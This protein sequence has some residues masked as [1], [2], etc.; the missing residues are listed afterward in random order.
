MIGEPPFEGPS[1]QENLSVVAVLEEKI[2][3]RLTGGSGFVIKIPE[4]PDS[5]NGDA[6]YAFIACT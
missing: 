3:A 5:E 6:P 1:C 4:P 2:S